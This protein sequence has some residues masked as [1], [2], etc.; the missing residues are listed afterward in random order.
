MHTSRLK[1]TFLLLAIL[2]CPI[3][4]AME[5]QSSAILAVQDSASLQEQLDF[6]QEN[7]RVYDNYRAI[8]EDIF[9]KM[10]KNTIDS[11]NAK[12]LQLARLQGE[13]EERNFEIQTL[14][15]DLNRNKEER[16]EAIRTKDSFSF[17]GIQLQK[18]VY[19]TIMWVLVLG[20]LG[21]AVI[22]FL[23]FKRSHMVTSHT[24]TELGN[25]QEEYEEYRKSS[26]EKYEKLVVSHHNELMKLK[27]S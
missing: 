10:K 19:N 3:P 4:Q 11:L 1:T 21:G 16:D 15:K 23:L 8:R 20:L 22:L 6:L 14:N 25:L 24:K 2:S 7:T 13:L 18:G 12:K 17:L 27:R 5:A 9:L 26:R